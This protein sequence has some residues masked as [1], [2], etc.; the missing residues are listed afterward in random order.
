M[1][2]YPVVIKA[3]HSET[4]DAVSLE[5]ETGAGH[6]LS[7][8]KAGQYLTLKMRYQRQE[9]L[10]CYS[11]SGMP[12]QK[13]VSIT[14]KKVPKGM[15]SKW[16]VDQAKVGDEIMVSGPHGR[17]MIDADPGR[18][19]VYYFFAAGSGITPV[20]SMIK[21]L[22]EHEPKSKIH[23]LYGN[24]RESDI[25]FK[26][27]IDALAQKYEGQLMI[28]YALSKHQKGFLWTSRSD[29][30]GLKGRIDGKMIAEFLKRHPAE[31]KDC[32]Y[33]LCGPGAF[34]Q[35]L[36]KHLI[37]MGIEASLVHK[38]YFSLPETDSNSNTGLE[39][40]TLCDLKV[41]LEK[42][43][44]QL[45]LNPGEKILDGLIRQGLNPPY[46]CSSGA[47]ATCIAK[48]IQGKVRMDVAL[49]LEEE[50]IAAGYILTCQAHPITEELEINY[51]V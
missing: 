51:D 40:L 48:V 14:V 11:Y 25:I 15:I 29:W 22:L 38:E 49:G 47:C 10:R 32:S 4:E 19:R 5:F 36:E 42:K 7:Q 35:D 6:P 41:Q 23:L 8:F 45:I 27:K 16:I 46:S 34:I 17:F 39:V 28:E 12:G 1:E 3:R 37:E 50:E 2:F 9:Y 20:F 13:T 21:V 31:I 43:N 30:S 44:H 26:S 33:Y 18:R 24:R